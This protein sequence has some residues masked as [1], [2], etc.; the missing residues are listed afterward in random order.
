MRTDTWGPKKDTE[1]GHSTALSPGV[2][3]PDSHLDMTA[4]VAM[5][6]VYSSYSRAEWE[7]MVAWIR[8]ESK[9]TLMD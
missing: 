9:K 4:P 8:L 3:R 6:I 1:C 5:L 7:V 2:P